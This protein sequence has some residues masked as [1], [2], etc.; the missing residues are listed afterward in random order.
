MAAQGFAEG[1]S[2]TRPPFFDGE[3]YQYWKMRMECFIRGTDFDLWQITYEGTD[4]VKQTRIDI[5]VSQYEQF[6]MLPNENIT[7][8]Y[9]RFSSI[10]VGSEDSDVDEVLSKLQKIL[11]K[12]KNGSRRIQKKERKEKEPVCYECKKPGQLRP[13]CP[14]LKKTGQTEKFKKYHKKFKRKAMAAAWENEKATSSDLSSSSSEKE[15][16]SLGA[17]GSRMHKALVESLIQGEH[18]Q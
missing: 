12:K 1:Q 6:K 2:V 15:Q 5:L 13:D 9:N 17:S 4:K 8:M 10:V 14:R 7:Q 18:R 11:K 3:D 16:D